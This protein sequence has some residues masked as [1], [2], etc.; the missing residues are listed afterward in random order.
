MDF[1]FKPWPMR[2][3]AFILGALGA[4][5]FAPLYIFPAILLSLSGIWFLLN[6]EIEQKSSFLKIFYLGWWFGLGHFT[7]GLYWIAHALTVDLAAFWWLVPFA[8]FGIPAILAVFTG[9]S[10]LLTK[11]WPYSG[12]SRAFAFTAIWVGVEW[13]RGYLFTGFPWNLLG[14]TWVFSPEMTQMSALLGIYGL[15]LLTLLMA[16]SLEYLFGKEKFSRNIAL[17]IYLLTIL[18]WVWGKG[19]LEKPDVIDG[20]SLAIRLVQPNIPQT[21]KWD[22]VQ[23]EANFQA[24]LRLTQ[25][26]SSLPL[27]AILWPET[28]VPFFLQQDTFRR[29]LIAETIPPNALL[30]TGALRRTASE[31]FW[32]SLLVLDSH[33]DVVASYDKSHLVPFGE[34]LPFRQT[35]DGLFGKG[36]IKKIT[37][38]TID[39]KAGSGPESISL[40]QGFP[41]FSGLVCYEV[42]FPGA[43]VNASQTRPGWMINVTNDAWYGNTSGPYQHLEMARM[44]AIEEGIPLVRI[45]NSGVSA[46]FDPYGRT[47]G[48]IGLGKKGV[49][50]V[51]LPSPL[52]SAPFYARW[53]D[54]VTFLLILGMLALA[55]IFSLKK[56]EAKKM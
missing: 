39:F 21:L 51:F 54:K 31:E 11:L 10:F 45:A 40:P 24:L 38:G 26:P 5:A 6:Y 13:L 1:L 20:S 7:L 18:C 48:N 37:T 55:W 50:D 36:S 33:G 8:L 56:K 49:L 43:V 53:G 2:G 16:I 15:S 27:K 25:T 30:F 28:A 17:C 22:P 23:R 52:R 19:R 32:N 12:I 4:L 47:V 9:V 29:T 35:L 3:A 34:Y 44:R 14:Y 41:T 42:I 46:V